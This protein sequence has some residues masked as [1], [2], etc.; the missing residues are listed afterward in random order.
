MGTVAL[1]GGQDGPQGDR[2]GASGSGL[3]V[4]LAI[5]EAEI[6][7]ITVQSQWGQIVQ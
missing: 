7:K 3:S 5:Q 6:G 1:G 4:I 2:P